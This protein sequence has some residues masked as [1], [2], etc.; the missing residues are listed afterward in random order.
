[1][2]KLMFMAA[3]L[4]PNVAFCARV[5]EEPLVKEEPR[6]F[7]PMMTD[8]F[9][10]ISFIM[11]FV[12]IGAVI[13]LF[14]QNQNYKNHGKRISKISNDLKAAI[15][16]IHNINA[17]LSPSKDEKKTPIQQSKPAEVKEENPPKTVKREVWQDFVDAYNNLANSMEVPKADVACVNFVKERGLKQF[18]LDSK[19]DLQ[20]P[21]FTEDANG[22][23][24]A[25][26][27]PNEER[28]AI[29]ISPQTTFDEK[30]YKEGGLKE[31]FASNF[32]DMKEIQKV[33]VKIPAIMT[34][35]DGKYT[36]NQ[37]GLLRF[38]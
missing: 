4:V 5:A 18:K 24:W 21:T 14:M 3:L 33:T 20:H 23:Y 32:E 12:L 7:S 27:V 22:V 30:F 1:M 6:L 26:Q 35:K 2:K 16:E 29:V 11:V 15:A 31:S 9:L 19:S 36:I 10:V 13:Y 17:V 8:V 25:Y 34:K 28:F 37:P 38:S